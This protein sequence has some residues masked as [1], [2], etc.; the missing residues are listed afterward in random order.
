MNCYLCNEPAEYSCN[1]AVPIVFICHEHL[2]IHKADRTRKHSLKVL[3]DEKEII[4]YK[5][6]KNKLQ[7]IN[8]EILFNSINQIEKIKEETKQSR[9]LINRIVL[10][11]YK[12]Y[13]EGRLNES[14]LEEMFAACK[15]ENDKQVFKSYRLIEDDS[16]IQKKATEIKIK[17]KITYNNGDEYEGD[18]ENGGRQGIGIYKYANGNVYEG[19]FMNGLLHS[20][21]IFT[22]KNGDIYEY[23]DSAKECLGIF[24]YLREGPNKGDIYQGEYK[25]NCKEGQGLYLYVNGDSYQGGFINDQFHG[26]GIFKYKN[27]PNKGDIYQG[28]Y[29]NNKREGQGL[30][31][32]ASGESYQGEFLNNEFH[33]IGVFKWSNGNVYGGEFKNY[34]KEGQ[35]ILKYANGK[36]ETGVWKNDIL[37]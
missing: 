32:Y 36:I 13:L 25:N 8:D 17:K 5:E 21:G 2:K 7:K 22:Y 9:C 16:L 14:F 15:N 11:L 30:Y 34:K 31:L 27:G 6:I 3:E 12:R 18:W 29:K 24:K 20:R 10:S 4:L 19:E 1:C 37:S 23:R 28:E 33:G 35:G 26:R